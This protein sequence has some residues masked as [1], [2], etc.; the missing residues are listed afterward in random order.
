MCPGAVC[1]LPR[2]Q[3]LPAALAGVVSHG[4]VLRPFS[5]P[6]PYPLPPPTPCRARLRSAGP[7]IF[8]GKLTK[9][10]SE[11]DVK[12]YFM[13]FG[14]VREGVGGLEPAHGSRV[15]GRRSLGCC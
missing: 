15:P 2:P 14:W 3:V 10:T 9:E 12:E 11:S 6:P 7:R 1:R 8:I 13:K 5:L 4:L